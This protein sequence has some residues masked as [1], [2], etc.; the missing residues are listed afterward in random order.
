MMRISKMAKRATVF[1]HINVY[2]DIHPLY[3][4]KLLDII[5]NEYD[6]SYRQIPLD[7]FLTFFPLCIF[8]PI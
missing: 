2:I 8:D 1:I 5:P 6:I 3:S 4:Y 7:F